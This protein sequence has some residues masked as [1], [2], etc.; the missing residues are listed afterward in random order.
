MKYRYT[1]EIFFFFWKNKMFTASRGRCE[2]CG[3]ATP[4]EQTA[5]PTEVQKKAVRTWAVG[6]GQPHIPAAETAV[7]VGEQNM[8]VVGCRGG[9]YLLVRQ[10]PLTAT[11]TFAFLVPQISPWLFEQPQLQTS[12]QLRRLSTEV[13]LLL[14]SQRTLLVSYWFCWRCTWSCPCKRRDVCVASLVSPSSG[15]RVVTPVRKRD[16]RTHCVQHVK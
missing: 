2:T 15:C 3:R 1:W 13:N 8:T 4:K 12:S 7:I 11:L 14:S 6:L 5:H 9:Q 16:D 10:S